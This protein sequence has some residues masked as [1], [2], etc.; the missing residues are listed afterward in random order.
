MNE[1]HPAIPYLLL[2]LDEADDFI[3]SCDEV[4]YHPFEVLKDIQGNEKKNFK[5]V[6]AGL[7]NVIRFRKQ[8]FLSDN[9][10]FPHLES[11]TIMPFRSMEA[12]ELLEIPLY[13]LG[14]RFEKNEETESLISTILGTTNYFPGLLQLYCSKLIQAMRKDYGGYLETQSPPYLIRKEHIKKV[15][16]Q[17]S[18]QQEIRDKFFITLKV[19]EDDYYY[20]LA[21]LAAYHVHS[22]HPEDGT[23]VRDLN[24]LASDL[25][26]EK[27]AALD[28]ENISALLEEM[29][30]LNVLQSLGNGRYRFAR[31]SFLQMM[32]TMEQ[33][34]DA[35]C[36]CMEDA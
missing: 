5:F 22:L 23:S 10:V 34:E 18:L 35:L 28:E 21:L 33:I 14:F 27:I 2:M 3:A 30:E 32:G 4:K 11:L 19:D 7:R 24:A 1:G 13:Y 6:V 29:R 26:I 25:G 9:N 12:R 16:A 31:Q 8:T 17:Q 36:R 15:L 20:L